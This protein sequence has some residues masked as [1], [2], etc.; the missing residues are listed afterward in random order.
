M[1]VSLCHWDTTLLSEHESRIS[2]KWVTGLPMPFTLKIGR[3]HFNT[4]RYS[5]SQGHG[6]FVLSAGSSCCA[7]KGH[8]LRLIPTPKKFYCQIWKAPN[9]EKIMFRFSLQAV[10]GWY[11]SRRNST[12]RPSLREKALHAK[13]PYAFQNVPPDKFIFGLF[14]TS[15]TSNS[16]THSFDHVFLQL[17]GRYGSQSNS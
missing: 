16:A 1:Y 13:L 4:H 9:W 3:L 10:V 12:M 11:K 8:Q 5:Q 6:C 2:S 7:E 14:T 15:R 17:K